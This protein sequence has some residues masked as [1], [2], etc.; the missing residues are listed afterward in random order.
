MKSYYIAG[1][2]VLAVVV[3]ICAVFVFSFLGTFIG[4][5]AGW[6]A[7]NVFYETFHNL[8]QAT[9]LSG[10]SMWEIGCGLGFISGF[11]RGNAQIQ[12]KA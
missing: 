10:V 3:F 2:S 5:L 6:I 8:Q 12:S 1:V 7:G 4:G 9:G 11:I